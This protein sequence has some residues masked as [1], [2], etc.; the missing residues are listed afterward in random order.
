MDIQIKTQGLTKQ[1]KLRPGVECSRAF[2]FIKTV[3]DPIDISGGM[4]YI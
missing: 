4:C 2:V 1:Y 3:S